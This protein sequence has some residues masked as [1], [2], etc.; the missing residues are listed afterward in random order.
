[1]QGIAQ[2]GPLA[3]T[4]DP[5]RRCC[6][7]WRTTGRPVWSRRAIWQNPSQ[8]HCLPG[9]LGRCTKL[10]SSPARTGSARGRIPQRTCHVHHIPAYEQRHQK[11]RKD[12]GPELVLRSG[13]QELIDMVNRTWLHIWRKNTQMLA[14]YKARLSRPVHSNRISCESVERRQTCTQSLTSRTIWRQLA[15]GS[16]TMRR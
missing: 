11:T 15:L 9:T 1:M 13:R 5:S 8:R 4:S 10:R 12:L 14:P 3:L 6:S 16:V 7:A 2:D